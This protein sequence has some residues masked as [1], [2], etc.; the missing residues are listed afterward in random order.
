MV[1]KPTDFFTVRSRFELQKTLL[2]GSKRKIA[3]AACTLEEGVCKCAQH[4]DVP[5]M[6]PLP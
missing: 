2:A 4:H 1:G 5:I 6:S 3:N